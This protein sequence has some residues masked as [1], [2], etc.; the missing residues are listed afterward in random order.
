MRYL[1]L[2]L[3]EPNGLSE[4]STAAEAL[5][6]VQQ[7]LPQL[8]FIVPQPDEAEGDLLSPM[9]DW[10]KAWPEFR[11]NLK[12]VRWVVQHRRKSGIRRQTIPPSVRVVIAKYIGQLRVE[13]VGEYSD[14]LRLEIVLC[15]EPGH[16]L[17]GFGSLSQFW[18][19][20]IATAIDPNFITVGGSVCGRCGKPLPSTKT[21]RPS[22]ATLCSSCHQQIWNE[23]HPEDAREGWRIQK[24]NQRKRERKTG[25]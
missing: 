13:A 10:R 17:I 8:F 24:A 21:G 25:K 23:R 4:D 7:Y 14:D 15:P 18:Q 6:W 16:Q 22:R 5:K 19:H 2:L 3:D 20:V 11:T 12:A 9:F 1:D